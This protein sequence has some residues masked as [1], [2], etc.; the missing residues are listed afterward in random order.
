MALLIIGA[1]IHVAGEIYPPSAINMFLSQLLSWMFLLG[2]VLAFGG[3]TIF[4]SLNFEPGLKSVDLSLFFFFV[5]LHAK[6][7]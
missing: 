4:E 3:Q 5:R 6:S 7:S 2:L 1:G